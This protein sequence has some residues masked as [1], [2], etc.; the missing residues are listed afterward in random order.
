MLVTDTTSRTP[1]LSTHHAIGAAVGLVVIITTY[2]ASGYGE[3]DRW[4]AAL[5]TLVLAIGGFDVFATLRRLLPFPGVVPATLLLVLAIM[6]LCVPETDHFEIAALLPL[7]VAGIELIGRRQ[8]GLEW[9][10]VA[11]AGV[12]WAGMLG[13]AGRQSALVGALFAWWPLVLVVLVGVVGIVGP[14]RT[15]LAAG[16][17]IAIGAVGAAAVA[18]TGGIA[19]SGAVAAGAAATERRSCRSRSLSSR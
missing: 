8:V 15:P 5:L 19:E 12:L 7:L 2:G 13:A 18:R 10:A 11:G 16:A 4:W 9:Y 17:V 1:L 14:I 3:G 6:Y